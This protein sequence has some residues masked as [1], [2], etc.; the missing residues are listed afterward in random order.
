[1]SKELARILS[2]LRGQTESYIKNSKHFVEKLNDISLEEFDKMVSFDVKSLFTKV[3]IDECLDIVEEKLRE[4]DTLGERTMMSP[5]TI[6]SLIKLCMTFT[7]FG[8]ENDI[9]EHKEGAPL[10]SPLSPILADIYME[11][12]EETAI[13]TSELKPELWYRYVDDTFVI[14]RHG[15]DEL[16]KFL[17][18]INGLRESIEFTMEIEA[19]NRIP[20]LDVMV[21]RKE[22]QIITS[23]YRKPIPIQIAT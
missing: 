11:F 4:D 19:D 22:K 3:P 23:I 15:I 13:N 16:R 12:F 7:Y 14:W 20:F 8:F 17:S 18:H 5:Q 10:G 2:P 9:Y 21:Y 6:S 1:M